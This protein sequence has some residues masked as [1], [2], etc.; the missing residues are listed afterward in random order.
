MMRSENRR[1]RRMT[2]L[3][4]VVALIACYHIG[5]LLNAAAWSSNQNKMS[6]GTTSTSQSSSP[7]PSALLF[8]STQQHQPQYCPLRSPSRY[9]SLV[10]R[11]GLSLASAS[12]NDSGNKELPTS[13]AQPSKQN[14]KSVNKNASKKR[15]PENKNSKRKGN[16]KR[17]GQNKNNKNN[18][19]RR[20]QGGRGNNNR[21]NDNQNRNKPRTNSDAKSR[22]PRPA[23]P[24]AK[25]VS[26]LVQNVRRILSTKPGNDWRSAWSILRREATIPL[27]TIDKKDDGKHVTVLP[28]RVYNDVLE[29]MKNERQ[30]WQDAIRLVRYMELGGRNAPTPA[31]ISTSNEGV[32][33]DD[34]NRRPWHI[35]PLNYDIY[36]TV[37]ECICKNGGGRKDAHDA[38]VFW[39]T[40]M[41]RKLEDDL[42]QEQQQSEESTTDSDA[43][44]SATITNRDRKLVRNS[45]QL[46]LSSLSK[47]GKWR[48]ALQLLDYIE[49]LS[50]P[51]RANIPLTVV[52][53]NTVLTCLARNRQVGQCQRLLQRLQE[54]SKEYPISPDEI[55][56]NSVIGACAST[57]KWREALAVL[58]E[59]Y[60]EPDFEPN[61]YIYTNAMRACAKGGNTQK[62]LGLLQV[63]KDKGL[64]VDSYCYTAVIDGKDCIMIWNWKSYLHLAYNEIDET[65]ELSDSL[66]IDSNLFFITFCI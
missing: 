51:D 36:H 13:S 48:D 42:L 58:D 21:K 24:S 32:A 37:I 33:D 4:S 8:Q 61:I 41:L 3:Q 52:Q 1:R 19:S 56:Y 35:P 16:P 53:Y 60:K 30:C 20:N 46:V 45:I 18:N 2:S 54:R 27:D 11:R 31:E 49:I 43:E 17:N 47:Q 34:Y 57:G 9:V 63:V 25:T 50:R 64:A 12:T 39:M 29:S 65:I 7:F 44:K 59:C 62:A 22:P 28:V 55:S 23:P 14:R 38:S 66:G 26:E 15:G 10:K 40:K 6:F 5:S